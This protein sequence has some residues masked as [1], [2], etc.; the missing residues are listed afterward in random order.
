MTGIDAQYPRDHPVLNGCMVGSHT[1]DVMAATVI[2]QLLLGER[3]FK[4]SSICR[5]KDRRVATVLAPW[6]TKS[7]TGYSTNVIIGN[8]VKFQSPILAYTLGN[9]EVNIVCMAKLNY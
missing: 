1:L 2:I 5:P 9:M 8:K 3:W 4:K 7:T 6:I